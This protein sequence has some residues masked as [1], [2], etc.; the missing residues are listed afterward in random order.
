MANPLAEQYQAPAAR[1]DWEAVFTNSKRPLVVDIGC[2]RGRWLQQLAPE[3][4]DWNFCGLEIYEPLVVA[5]NEATR[6]LGNLHYVACNAAV[7]MDSLDFESLGA[8]TVILR[9]ICMH[10]PAVK[11]VA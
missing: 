1:P 3:Q 4:P 9:P 8:G 10:R 7:S 11:W 6:D 2:A 5:A